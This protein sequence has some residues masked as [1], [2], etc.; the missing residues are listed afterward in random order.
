M[1]NVDSS[2]ERGCL[3]VVSDP[4][5][6]TNTASVRQT[7]LDNGSFDQLAAPDAVQR[8]GSNSAMRL[9]A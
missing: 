4:A 2:N 3:D 1:P 9:A 6:A 8:C 7:R 5:F